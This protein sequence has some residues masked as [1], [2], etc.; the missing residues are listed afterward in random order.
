MN[1][2]I[3]FLQLGIMKNTVNG[4]FFSYDDAMTAINDKQN[5]K[6]SDNRQILKSNGVLSFQLSFH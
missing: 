3:G 4:C 5:H 1:P 6:I 2:K